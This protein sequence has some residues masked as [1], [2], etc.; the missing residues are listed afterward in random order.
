MVG[1]V[2]VDLD[3][4]KAVRISELGKGKCLLLFHDKA[5]N[6][7]RLGMFEVEGNEYRPITGTARVISDADP[8]AETAKKLATEIGEEFR[9]AVAVVAS[10]PST[11]AAKKT[12]VRKKSSK[13]SAITTTKLND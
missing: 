7:F 8:L 4:R 3:G 5:Q 9:G 2:S 11:P 13:N 1:Q 12:A 10:T 6:V